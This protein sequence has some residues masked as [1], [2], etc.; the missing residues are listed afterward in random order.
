LVALPLSKLTVA[1]APQE[2]VALNVAGETWRLNVI[3][4]IDAEVPVVALHAIA[5]NPV[6][7]WVTASAPVVVVTP[8]PFTQAPP[9]PHEGAVAPVE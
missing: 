5:W 8:V 2:G 9:A 4:V 3:G 6:P 1:L 7:D